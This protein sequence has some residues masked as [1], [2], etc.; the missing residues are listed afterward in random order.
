LGQNFGE[1]EKKENAGGVNEKT[2]G[3][4][5]GGKRGDGGKDLTFEG[6]KER[7]PGKN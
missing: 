4:Y 2:A 7:A 5:S 3:I 1:K 6:N